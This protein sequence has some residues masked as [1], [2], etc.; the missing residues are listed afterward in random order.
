[1]ESRDIG[2]VQRGQYFTGR[3]ARS[4]VTLSA[5]CPEWIVSSHCG[6]ESY[7]HVFNQKAVFEHL[8]I[9]FTEIWMKAQLYIY[10]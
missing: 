3:S 6:E 8:W 2:Y 5:G 4:V 9:N 7:L 1:M 10:K